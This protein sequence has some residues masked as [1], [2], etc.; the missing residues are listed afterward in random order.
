MIKAWQ[1]FIEWVS[2][3]KIEI[4]YFYCLSMLIMCSVLSCFNIYFM[5]KLV[6]WL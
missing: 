3:H 4:F 1:S 2:N 6:G 5:F